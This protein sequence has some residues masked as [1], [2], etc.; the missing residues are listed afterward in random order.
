MCPTSN[1]TITNSRKEALPGDAPID[2]DLIEQTLQQIKEHLLF[3]RV[4][5][6][7][8]GDEGIS[9]NEEGDEALDIDNMASLQEG[10]AMQQNA[11]LPDSDQEG[12]E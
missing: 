8:G 2:D 11:N 3:D 6:D 12:S 10:L 1:H 4:L 7:N 5:P 9:D